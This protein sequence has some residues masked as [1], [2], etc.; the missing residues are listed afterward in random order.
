MFA[1]AHASKTY[2]HCIKYAAANAHLDE[3]LALA[4]EK[5][6]FMWKG[7]GMLNK[8]C[9]LASPRVIEL[10]EFRIGSRLI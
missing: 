9:L 2:I 1:L 5:T 8:G 10:A 7:R 6:A 4:G 3:L